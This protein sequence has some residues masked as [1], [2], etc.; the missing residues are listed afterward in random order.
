MEKTNTTPWDPA[1]HLET[2]EDMA[3]Y[4]NVALDEGDVS[5][6]MAVLRDIARAKSDRLPE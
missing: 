2:E 3:A 6:T 1:E 4:L 5:L